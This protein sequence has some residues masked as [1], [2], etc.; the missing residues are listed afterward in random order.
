MESYS[1]N[2]QGYYKE[3]VIVSVSWFDVGPKLYWIWPVQPE[4]VTTVN[5]KN[6]M[7][8]VYKLRKHR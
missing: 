1:S 7:P 3:G 6:I 5:E 8:L 2:V 4:G